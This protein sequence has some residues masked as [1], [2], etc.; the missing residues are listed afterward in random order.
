[1]HEPQPST[2]RR[3]DGPA[4]RVVGVSLDRG[5]QRRLDG[6]TLDIDGPG[7]TAV[8]GSN[9]A[10]KSLLFRVLDGLDAPDA[11][12]VIWQGAASRA[13]V[14]Q[15]PVLLR[16]SVA[17]N[18]DFVLPR[19]AHLQREALLARVDLLCRARQP[20]R[21]LSGGEAQRLA[22]ARAL[23]CEPDVLMLD[24]PTASLDPASTAMIETIVGETADRGARVL[25]VTHD[26][27]Q[28]RRIASDVVFLHAGR[29]VEHRGAAGFFTSPQSAEAQAYLEGRLLVP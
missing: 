7:V 29:L 17:A 8:M 12:E 1:M 9:G 6:I 14:F 11:G 5:G 18:L 23:A 24:E 22:L 25:F 16:R 13:L 19:R 2:F 10:G 21:A 3:A 27:L 4:L 28:A 15:T 20:A 26:P